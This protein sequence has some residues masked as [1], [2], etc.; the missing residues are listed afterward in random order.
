MDAGDAEDREVTML[1]LAL[2]DE[3]KGEAWGK[4][5]DAVK[6]A[7]E[8]Y[9]L[10]VEVELVKLQRL[11]RGWKVARLERPLS[12]FANPMSVFAVL[13]KGHLWWRKEKRIP[14]AVER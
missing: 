10:R 5:A 13:T 8:G 1:Y 7:A 4:V 14:F 11:H 3:Q 9:A 2:N 6:M 12:P